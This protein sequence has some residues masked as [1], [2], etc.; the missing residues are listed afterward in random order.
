MTDTLTVHTKAHGMACFVCAT[1]DE[2]CLALANDETCC[3]R[4]ATTAGVTHSRQL[5][6]DGKWVAVDGL[7]REVACG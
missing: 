3:K 7:P 1:T 2:C 6:R 4:C 5:G